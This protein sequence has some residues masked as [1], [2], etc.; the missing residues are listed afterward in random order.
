[1]SICSVAEK[2]VSEDLVTP[3]VLLIEDEI[4]ITLL[5]T[6]ALSPWQV[7]VS[8]AN[9]FIG[10]EIELENPAGFDLVI[11]DLVMPGTNPPDLLRLISD[12]SQCPVMVYSGN[13]SDYYIHSAI[14]IL[15]RPIWFIQ[16]PALFT[17]ER[18]QRI[19]QVSNI[20][21]RKKFHMVS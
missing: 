16:K 21:L 19:F 15:D 14:A 3:R 4:S 8:V 2:F 6:R 13:L 12:K 17:R 1:M 5:L 20:K 7:E 10:S 11:T 18:I 9:S